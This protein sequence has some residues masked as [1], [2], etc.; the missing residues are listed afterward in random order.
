MSLKVDKT[1]QLVAIFRENDVNVPNW[2]APLVQA[3]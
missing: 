3:D 1:T 2:R